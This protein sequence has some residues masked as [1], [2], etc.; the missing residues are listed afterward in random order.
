[1]LPDP[2]DGEAD[3]GGGACGAV[4]V[5]STTRS[6]LRRRTDANRARDSAATTPAASPVATCLLRQGADMPG[7]VQS[8]Q[9]SIRSSAGR[10]LV[11][12]AGRWLN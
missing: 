1:V 12:V 9:I 3:G 5:F 7:A 10:S 6:C 2:A 4:V 8:M 11:D